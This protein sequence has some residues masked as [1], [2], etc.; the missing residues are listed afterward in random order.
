MT[1]LKIKKILFSLLLVFILSNIFLFILNVKVMPILIKEANVEAKK[2]AIEVLRNTGLNKINDVLNR[3][4]VYTI[5]KQDDGQIE[6]ID[7]N[8]PVL[9]EVLIIVAQEV[10]NKLK[11]EEEK[12]NKMVYHIPLSAALNNN[13]FYSVGPKVPIKVK[14][15]GSVSLDL[16]TKVKEYG[17]NSALIE[18]YV[19]VSVTQSAIVPMQSKDVNI[20]SEIPIVLKVV[21]GVNTGLLVDTKSSYNLPID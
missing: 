8:I 13:L 3:K 6:S 15:K 17:V 20:S 7:F 4:D 14:Y 18:V 5:V 2:S 1:K 16:K 11:E 21:K 12:N 19:I 9:N 10:R